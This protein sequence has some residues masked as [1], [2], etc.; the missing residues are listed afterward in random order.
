MVVGIGAGWIFG[1]NLRLSYLA[2][3]K[4]VCAYILPGEYLTREHCIGILGQIY[5]TI[6]ASFY[7]IITGKFIN[8]PSGLH[9]KIADCLK[10]DTFCQNTDIEKAGIFNHFSCEIVFLHGNRQ[11][12][13][14]FRYLKTGIGNTAVIFVRFPG[15]DYKQSVGQIVQRRGIFRRFLLLSESSA[16]ADPSEPCRGEPRR[17]PFRERCHG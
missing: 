7:A 1:K 2:Y 16:P 15:A 10:G 12:I 14:I 6:M 3:K 17:V 13:G 4:H 5:Q 8:I 11:L 9:T